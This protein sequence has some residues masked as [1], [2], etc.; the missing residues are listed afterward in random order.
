MTT[1]DKARRAHG[2]L[3]KLE[4]GYKITGPDLNCLREFLPKLPKQKTL[5]EIYEDVCLSLKKVDGD[6]WDDHA[7]YLEVWLGELKHHLHGL[8]QAEPAKP[9]LPA[10]MRIAEHEVLGRVV[11]SPVA[12][13]SGIYLILVLDSSNSNGANC[14]YEHYDNLTFIDQAPACTIG[15]MNGVGS[16]WVK[17]RDGWLSNRQVLRAGGGANEQPG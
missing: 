1:D 15:A 12:D 9:A 14:V 16:A 2:L 6:D 10:G 7:V 11:V 5:E 4:Q 17:E 8:I 3:D 13:K